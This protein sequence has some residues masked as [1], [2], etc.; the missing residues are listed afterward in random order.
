MHFKYKLMTVDVIPAGNVTQHQISS[1]RNYCPKVLIYLCI[2]VCRLN[3]PYT[4]YGAPQMQCNYGKGGTFSQH[5]GH[6]FC[7][8]FIIYMPTNLQC[9]ICNVNTVTDLLYCYSEIPVLQLASV[10]SLG[11]CRTNR[12]Q[13]SHA[14]VH[15]CSP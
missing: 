14:E 6:S 3:A 4:F 15:H 9:S 8:C 1:S 2:A 11:S 10:C 7:C 12:D 5:V 13:E